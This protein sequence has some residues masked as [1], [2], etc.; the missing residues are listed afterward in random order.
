MMNSSRDV[1]LVDA[2]NEG[3]ARGGGAAQRPHVKH[4]CWAASL[5]MHCIRIC[6]IQIKP[7]PLQPRCCSSL[8]GSKSTGTRRHAAA[9][10]MFE[11]RL[12]QGE[13][14][15]KIIDSIKDLVTDANFDCSATG[16]GLQAMDSSHVSLVALLLRADGFEHYR[17]DRGLSMGMNLANFAKMLKV[18]PSSP[19][20]R[21]Q[22]PRQGRVRRAPNAASA[23]RLLSHG[24]SPAAKL[25]TRSTPSTAGLFCTHG[26]G[27]ASRC[28]ELS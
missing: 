28:T 26:K 11:A 15:K 16:F 13:L 1:L 19:R 9:D 8:A 23:M 27:T 2:A 22:N 5:R 7:C 20:H 10:T 14:L 24:P 6:L 4:C 12:L 18:R 21:V 25:C 3:D 17:C